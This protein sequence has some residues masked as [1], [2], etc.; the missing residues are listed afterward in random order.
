MFSGG[1][2]GT[3]IVQVFAGA[4][5]VP[6]GATIPLKTSMSCVFQQRDMLLTCY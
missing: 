2:N 3:S 6:V 5:G 4:F 1:G